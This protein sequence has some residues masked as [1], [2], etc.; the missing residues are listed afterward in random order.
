[1]SPLRAP[2]LAVCLPLALAFAP[3]SRAQTPPAAPAQGEQPSV[4]DDREAVEAG[5][6]WLALIDAGKAGAAWD[7]A[8]G[9]LKRAV[10]RAKFVAA[11]RDQRKPLGKLAARTPVRFGR[12]HEM[13]GAPPGDYA[14]VEYEAKFA[15]GK[16]AEVLVWTLE[17]GDIWRV[18]GYEYR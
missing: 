15:R 9:Q 6:K 16:L 7:D 12:S 2:W 10:P 14:I 11:M 1:M 5:G 3:A 13:P 4:R 17:D 8:A 18:A